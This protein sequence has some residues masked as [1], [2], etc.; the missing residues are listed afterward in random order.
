MLGG[1]RMEDKGNL[2]L[3]KTAMKTWRSKR[4]QVWQQI[5]DLKQLFRLQKQ[6]LQSTLLLWSWIQVLERLLKPRAL[7][8]LQKRSAKTQAFA[9]AWRIILTWGHIPK[10]F[11][12]LFIIFLLLNTCTFLRFSLNENLLLLNFLSHFFHLVSL[13]SGI[14]GFKCEQYLGH[15]ISAY[16][17]HGDH[18]AVCFLSLFASFKCF[19]ESYSATT[20]L[21]RKELNDH[22]LNIVEIQPISN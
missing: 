22:Q 7:K 9:L 2:F 18:Q 10:H 21:Q 19:L 16:L 6:K 17:I 20:Q 4:F 12:E 14:S 13:Y 5:E 15:W 11:C 1:L 3:P 8:W